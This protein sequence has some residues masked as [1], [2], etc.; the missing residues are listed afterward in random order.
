LAKWIAEHFPLEE[1]RRTYARP[2]RRQSA[3]PDIARPRYV[4]PEELRHTHTFGV[5]MDTSGSMDRKLLGKCLGAIASYSAAQ[6]VKSIRLVY[7]DAQP[8]DEGYVPVDSLLSKVQVKGRGGT[9][10]Q[11]AINLLENARDFP[12]GAPIL[13]LSDGYFEEDL[14]IQREHAFLVPRRAWLPFIP[15]GPV[16]EFKE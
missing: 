13:V 7:C 8:Y 9:V 10:L 4:R 1:S 3:T 14:L 5:V 11:P 15:K 16:F 2:S 12:D 6:E